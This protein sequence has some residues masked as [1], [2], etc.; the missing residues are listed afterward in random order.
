[1]LQARK[2]PVVG[3]FDL[4]R[5]L[6][7]SPND[8]FHHTPGVWSRILRNLDFVASYGGLLEINTSALRKGMKEPYPCVE[9]CMVSLGYAH[10]LAEYGT[11]TML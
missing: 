3:H 7:D 8:G 1:M 9:I 11:L 10:K 4:I 2:P 5:L 6:S